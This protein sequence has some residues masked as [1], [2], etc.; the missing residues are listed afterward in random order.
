MIIKPKMRGFICTTAHP[1]GCAQNVYDQI[2]YVKSKGPIQGAKNV[3]VIG[4]STGYGLAS[5]IAAA[6][7]SG[8]KTIGVF[9]ERPAADNRTATA[10]WYNTAAFEEKAAEAGLYSRSINGDAFSNAVKQETVEL[11]K[12]DLGKVDLV[13]YSL[14]SPRRTD[15]VTGETY[16]SVIKPIGNA[17]CNKTVNFHTGEVTNVSIEPATDTEIEQ[18]LRVMGGEDWQ[19][20]MEALKNADVLEKDAITVAYSYIG[21][22][23]THAIYKNGTIGKAKEHLEATA[24]SITD[25]M[26]DL[27][28]KAYISIN[29]ALVTQSSSAIPVVP[30][31]I[32]ILYKVMKSKGLHEGCIEQAYRLLRSFLY[33]PSLKLDDSGRIRIDDLEMEKDVQEEVT[34]LWNTI[35]TQTINDTS[36]IQG[37]RDEFLKLFGFGFSSLDYDEDTDSMKDIPG[38]KMV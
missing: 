16:N 1:A 17:F 5:R 38:I 34:Q 13:I 14:A 30:L 8:S 21:P 28:I 37:Y 31:Y 12:K 18:T 4:S 15:P 6:F 29:K 2:A 22:E 36:D 32:S 27:G 19:L 20:W 9:F 24:K 11:I 26:K 7:G 23:V 3:L 35:D 25:N 33:A 10:G